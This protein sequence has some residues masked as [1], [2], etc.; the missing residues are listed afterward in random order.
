[1]D[2]APAGGESAGW[3]EAWNRRAPVK[4]PPERSTPPYWPATASGGAQV[5]CHTHHVLSPPSP[6]LVWPP[7]ETISGVNGVEGRSSCWP[8]R[9]RMALG[10]TSADS[11]IQR[12]L[13][14]AWFAGPHFSIF[15]MEGVRWLL[16]TLVFLL[17]ET[18]RV[19]R[20]M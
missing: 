7:K 16:L 3:G 13:A 11:P 20:P 4:V 8:Y 14:C 2:W 19:S 5:A 9:C 1:M 18:K 10:A 12:E 15:R 6:Q 17:A